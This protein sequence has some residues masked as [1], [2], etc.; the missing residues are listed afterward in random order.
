MILLS[1]AFYY[2]FCAPSPHLQASKKLLSLP[3]LK[4]VQ[5][6]KKSTTIALAVGVVQSIAAM[7]C[8]QRREAAVCQP[9]NS[10]E[11]RIWYIPLS[12]L[13]WSR[14]Y[15]K[16]IHGQFHIIVWTSLSLCNSLCLV[17]VFSFCNEN[18]KP[19][20]F[21]LSVSCLSNCIVSR[22]NRD[23]ERSSARL[24][25]YRVQLPFVSL[26]MHTSDNAV[27]TIRYL[28]LEDGILIN[29][30]AVVPPPQQESLQSYTSRTV[31]GC[32]SVVQTLISTFVHADSQTYPIGALCAFLQSVSVSQPLLPNHPAG[33]NHNI[34]PSSTLGQRSV[35]SKRL[36]PRRWCNKNLHKS[37]WNSCKQSASISSFPTNICWCLEG[38]SSTA[39]SIPYQTAASQLTLRE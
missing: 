10:R 13:Q 9:S 12:F 39:T 18:K 29:F 4:H 21:F 15:K 16:E 23:I 24:G 20:P 22:T 25:L 38:P 6:L 36:N 27:L 19:E 8:M 31:L 5:Q 33:F 30:G 1:P 26:V 32:Q 7:N 37:V 2:L 3:L 35:S 14:W 17:Q 34:Q 28:F 11:P